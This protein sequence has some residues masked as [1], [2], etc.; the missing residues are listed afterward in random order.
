LSIYTDEDAQERHANDRREVIGKPGGM[1]LS[2]EQTDMLGESRARVQRRDLGIADEAK[3]GRT[4]VDLGAGRIWIENYGGRLYLHVTEP[5]W[6]PDERLWQSGNGLRCP[7]VD[8]RLNFILRCFLAQ[9][10][11]ED[12]SMRQLLE[13]DIKGHKATLVECW[14]P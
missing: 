6:V 10:R 14:E 13:L 3:L 2:N 8:F 4:T 5:K 11:I 12:P 9:Q 7:A 1:E